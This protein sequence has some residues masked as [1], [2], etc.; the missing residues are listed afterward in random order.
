MSGVALFSMPM[1]NPI[2]AVRMKPKE[3]AL[4]SGLRST[5]PSSAAMAP[6]IRQITSGCS[7]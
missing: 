6:K 2:I 1:M 4:S 7:A 5:I 3:L